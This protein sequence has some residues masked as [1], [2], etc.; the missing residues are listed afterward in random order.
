MDVAPAAGTDDSGDNLAKGKIA[1]GLEL[2]FT[3]GGRRGEHI[4][5]EEVAIEQARR[6]LDGG[7]AQRQHMAGQP[8]PV[9]LQGGS[10]FGADGDMRRPGQLRP[11]RW[12]GV[13]VAH[14]IELA[15]VARHE[16]MRH[17]NCQ[18]VLGVMEQDDP[19]GGIGR[20]PA[21]KPA[22]AVGQRQPGIGL[23]RKGANLGH[24]RGA[25]IPGIC[26]HAG[27]HHDVAFLRACGNHL[28][29]E[30]PMPAGG[31]ELGRHIDVRRPVEA[32]GGGGKRILRSTPAGEFAD[33]FLQFWQG[34]QGPVGL[35]ENSRPCFQRQ[36]LDEEGAVICRIGRH[37][38]S[39]WSGLLRRL[40]APRQV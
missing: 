12:P 7:M 1:L 10:L 31:I 19:L 5:V 28:L 24:A 32:D 6:G 22:V 26:E 25:V 8:G 40:P 20:Q 9:R 21:A 38:R 3:A 36:P 23:D 17:G 4:F 16:F 15:P 27:E 2:V 35:V 39:P 33:L 30:T 29:Q 13:T 11:E 14:D 18:D 34:N 37:L